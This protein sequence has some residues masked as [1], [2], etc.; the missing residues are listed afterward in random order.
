MNHWLLEK[1]KIYQGIPALIVNK[2]TYYYADIL[3]YCAELDKTFAIKPGSVLYIKGSYNLYTVAILLWSLDKNIIVV[4]VSL[5]SFTNYPTYSEIIPADFLIDCENIEQKPVI[6]Q[7][8]HKGYESLLTNRLIQEQKGALVLFS[9]GTTGQPKA[10]VHDLSVFLEKFHNLKKQFVGIAFL[11]YDHIGGLNTLF[12]VLSSGGTLVSSVSTHP[13]DVCSLIEQYQVDLLPT[14]P[15]FLRMLLMS[16]ALKKYNL[17]S[18]KIISYG[19]EYMHESTLRALKKALPNVLF[20]Q[21]YG[22]TEI[23]ILSTQ[24]KAADSTWLK[25]DA[26]KTPYKIVD[27]VLWVKVSNRS[28]QGYLNAEFNIDGDW[29]NTQDRVI[30]DGDYLKIL[31]RKTDLINVGGNKVD[32]TELEDFFLQHAGVKDAVVFAKASPILGQIV[33]VKIA[34]QQNTD[35]ELLK[36]Q[37]EEHSKLHLEPFKIPAC[38]VFETEIDYSSRWK[39]VRGI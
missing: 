5:Q 2:K 14:T 16:E 23:G 30:Q 20:K 39:K 8:S 37:L 13:L 28:L 10:A 12:S 38:F 11:N 4:P 7:V 36:K 33:M 35:V 1:I 19:T 29:V 22:S 17:L 3:Q 31:G 25:I 21:T 34:P 27:D 9:S 6:T 15:S 26:Q 32:P 24:S 18:L